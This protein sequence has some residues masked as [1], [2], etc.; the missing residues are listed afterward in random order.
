MLKGQTS[1]PE[2]VT[3]KCLETCAK[4]R[5]HKGTI[6]SEEESAQRDS[7]NDELRAGKVQIKIMCMNEGR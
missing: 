6:K 3:H 4:A 2:K 1:I 5:V 7:I